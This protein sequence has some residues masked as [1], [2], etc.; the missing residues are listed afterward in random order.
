[1]R[2][3]AEI[4]LIFWG[5]AALVCCAPNLNKGSGYTT[6]SGLES[7]K[8]DTI[9]NGRVVGLYPLRNEQ[10]MEVCVTNFGGR[11]VTILT[12]DRDD[13]YRE[14]TLGF[15]NIGEYVKRRMA[16]GATVGRYAGRIA[17]GRLNIDGRTYQTD[18][19]SDGLTLHGGSRGWMN[20]P[21]EVISYSDNS[22]EM[23]YRAEDGENGFPGS[24]TLL[25]SYTLTQEN[26][27][28]ISYYA[29]TD[30]PT[31]IN[32]TNHTFFNLSGD[33]DIKD[34]EI[35]VEADQYTPII[36]S[37]PSSELMPVTGTPMDMR[38][39]TSI[40][41]IFEEYETYEQLR[42]QS[43]LDHRWVF[44]FDRVAD[45]EQLYLYSPRS[46]I[47]MKCYT[48]QPSVHISTAGFLDGSIVGR[49]GKPL[50]KHG[51][52]CIETQHAT[53]PPVTRVGRP[54]VYTCRYEFGV[55]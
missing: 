23:R 19:N 36:N 10:G 39:R 50:V 46:G 30:M 3:F 11:I 15:D 37:V 24:V 2:R 53:T 51:G 4:A 34:H 55:E 12:K 44:N 9:I 1:M 25:M 40:S 42:I 47:T 41:K 45:R 54:Y 35:R 28:E 43:G 32:L 31:M 21:F 14:V 22:I 29:T 13:E 20:E 52:I 33:G 17:G 38:Q 6:L 18:L 8:F 48:T 26:A 16:I 5:V 27:I 7:V 49:G